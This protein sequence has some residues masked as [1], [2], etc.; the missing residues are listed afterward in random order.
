MPIS[1]DKEKKRRDIALSCKELIVNEPIDTISIAK[2]AKVAS[3]GKG[4]F[5]EYF[6]DKD[7]LIFELV[8]ILMQ[9]QNSELEENLKYCKD[10]R[11]KVKLFSSFFYEEDSFELRELYKEFKAVSLVSATDDVIEF[12]SRCFNFYSEWIGTIIDEAIESKELKEVARRL[13]LVVYTM[14]EGMF[15]QSVT[16]KDIIDLRVDLNR[17]IDDIF[18]LVEIKD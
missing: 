10:T 6:K 8:N 12:N 18:D 1:V 17:A 14:S 3:I 7:D 4:T 16:T 13:I 11:E 2:L 5:Y 15:I 9:K